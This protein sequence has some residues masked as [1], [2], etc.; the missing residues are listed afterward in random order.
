MDAK[1]DNL[2]DKIKS[3]GVEEAQ[4]KSEEIIKEAQEEADSIVKEAEE[5]AEI[6]KQNQMKEIERAKKEAVEELKDEV[7][8]IS[9]QAAGRII[10]EKLSEEKHEEI[11]NEYIEQLDREK[12]GEIK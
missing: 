6:I 4:K 11:I 9:L 12:I 7:A 1:L 2:I 8:S 3:E 5:E 10:E